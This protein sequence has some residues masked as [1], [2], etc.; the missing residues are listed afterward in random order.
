M[1]EPVHVSVSVRNRGLCDINNIEL[2]DS[3][4]SGMHLTE[5]LDTQ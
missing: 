2:K 5:R 3:I 4:V 1:G